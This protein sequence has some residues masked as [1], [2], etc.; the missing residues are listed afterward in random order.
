M[1]S[2]TFLNSLCNITVKFLIIFLLLITFILSLNS[3]S[4]S[5][6]AKKEYDVKNVRI[7]KKS[8]GRVDWLHTGKMLIA[9]D[10]KGKNR[11]FDLYIM[12]PNGSGEKC[13]TCYKK[14]LPRGHRGQPAWHPSGNYI[15]FQVENRNSKHTINEQPSLGINN[16]LYLITTDGKRMWQ[17]LKTPKGGAVLHPK[18]SHNGKKLLWSER[19]EK[20]KGSRWGHWR[21]KIA[22][23]DGENH[24]LIN[25]KNIE[26]V[27]HRWYESHGFSKDDRVLYFSGNLNKGWGNDIYSY[28]LK[29]GKLIRLTKN[30]DTWDEMAEL[31]PSGDKIAFISSRFFNWSKRLGFLTLRTEIFL[32]NPDGTGVQQV[33]HLNDKNHIYLIGDI[34]WSPDGKKILAAAYE[35]KSRKAV[36]IEVEFE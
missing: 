14:E 13:L 3:L 33:T 10:K 19:Y 25:I 23:F 32:M 2:R 18:F 4:H 12:N 17:L 21:L 15:V 36:T 20:G 11:K 1:K 35:K 8:G 9:F 34:T 24:K 31:S 22:D 16:D 27:K 26:P 28:N 7:L 6:P 30:R 5:S 29:T